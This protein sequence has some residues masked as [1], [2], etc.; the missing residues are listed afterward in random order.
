M[1][2]EN[3]RQ[4]ELSWDEYKVLPGHSYSNIKGGTVTPTDKMLLGTAV[5]DYLLLGQYTG[6]HPLPLVRAIASKLALKL[7][8]LLPYLQAEVAIT[9]D[10]VHAGLKMPYKGRLD[11]TVMSQLVIDI[12]VTQVKNIPG[13]LKYFG[14]NHQVS[15]YS[16]G[17]GAKAALLLTVHPGTLETNLFTIPITTDWWEHQIKRFGQPA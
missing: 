16:L 1:V 9:A 7:G 8:V 3:M 2:I 12:K 11:L 13:V 14:W 6:T 15:G 17:S 10:F 4:H 5:H